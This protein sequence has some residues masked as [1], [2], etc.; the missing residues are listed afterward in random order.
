M[1]S[2]KVGVRSDTVGPQDLL[3][4]VVEAHG[5][6]WHAAMWQ[7]QAG[8]GERVADLHYEL[9]CCR[10]HALGAFELRCEVSGG[11]RSECG[12]AVMRGTWSGRRRASGQDRVLLV[13]LSEIC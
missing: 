13:M 2:A 8:T 9:L 11:V 3:A 10:L 12:G 7:T 1:V 4:A 6:N 5:R